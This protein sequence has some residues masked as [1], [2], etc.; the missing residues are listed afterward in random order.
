MNYNTFLTPANKAEV[1]LKTTSVSVPL[2]EFSCPIHP[3]ITIK[4]NLVYL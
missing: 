3:I 4:L 1:K 2:I